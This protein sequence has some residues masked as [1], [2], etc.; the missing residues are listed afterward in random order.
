[1]NFFSRTFLIATLS[2]LA[3][4][5]SFSQCR[6]L[7]AKYLPKLAPFEFDGQADY[8]VEEGK[9]VEMVSTFL[10]GEWYRVVFCT[11]EPFENCTLNIFEKKSRNLVYTS[12]I[13]NDYHFWDVKV[14][15]TLDYIIE[16]VVANNPQNTENK[17]GCVSILIGSKD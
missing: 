4:G 10:K 11:P 16:V 3:C 15:A 13:T 17:K 6:D 2:T 7:G 9:S 5:Y 14:K 1:M 8:L 12:K